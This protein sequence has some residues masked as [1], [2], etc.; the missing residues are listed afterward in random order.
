MNKQ[1]ERILKALQA[2]TEP[3]AM[4]ELSRIGSGKDN[5]WCASFTRRISDLREAGHDIVVSGPHNRTCYKL[6]RSEQQQFTA[7][8]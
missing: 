2:T 6:I 7:L 8:N 1:S 3:V 4:P 5:G